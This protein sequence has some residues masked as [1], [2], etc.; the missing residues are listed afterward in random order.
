MPESPTKGDVEKADL[1]TAFPADQ[2][3]RSFTAR[4]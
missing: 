3:M 4:T 1:D 2:A